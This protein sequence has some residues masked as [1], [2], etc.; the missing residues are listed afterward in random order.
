MSSCNDDITEWTDH[1]L[2][3]KNNNDDDLHERKS[4]EHRR[5]AKAWKEEVRR[6][7]EEKARR[8]AEKEVQSSV[9][10]PSKGKQRDIAELTATLARCY[11]CLDVGVACEIQVAEVRAPGRHTANA[12]EKAGGVHVTAGREEEGMNKEEED[13]EWGREEN[14]DTLGTLVEMLAL[15]VE[16][17]QSLLCIDLRHWLSRFSIYTNA[18]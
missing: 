3:E 11:R 9:A 1:Q 10:G 14:R 2:R 13:W 4:A 5:R 6:K 17:I 12:A 18:T 16:E 8:K 7:A 15:I